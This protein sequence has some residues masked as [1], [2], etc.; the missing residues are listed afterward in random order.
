MYSRWEV[1]CAFCS[2]PNAG[3]DR[4]CRA[5]HKLMLPEIPSQPQ[6]A[7]RTQT[8]NV[9]PWPG[10]DPASQVA[11]YPQS[12]AA[13]HRPA[14]SGQ[15][16]TGAGPQPWPPP[17]PGILPFPGNG[18]APAHLD[19]QAPPY[20]S[21][22]A[23]GQPYQGMPAYAQQP[24]GSAPFYPSG[25]W[26]VQPPQGQAPALPSHPADAEPGSL[27]EFWPRFGAL[28]VDYC[29]LAVVWFTL[30]GVAAFVN[31][32]LLGLLATFLIPPLYFIS[33]WA[34]SGRTPGYR[35]A[36]LQLIKSDGT[37]PDLKHSVVRYLGTLLSW[38]FFCLGY[39]WMLWD[40]DHQT[41][42]DKIA[43]TNVVNMR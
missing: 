18:H 27:A 32:T 24:P 42:H 2:T 23:Y 39:L 1:L 26:P 9:Q 38:S 30:V 41:W 34:T 31:S 29:V 12:P 37:R 20:A 3:G 17:S 4:F 15:P 43:D 40:R 28:M 35:A 11:R 5:C 13:P 16:A 6:A 33:F 8:Q 22:T 25:N 10:V 19:L 7:N 21:G 36:G 14:L